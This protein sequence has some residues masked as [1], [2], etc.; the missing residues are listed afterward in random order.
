MESTRTLSLPI[1]IG[2]RLHAQRVLS[3]RSQHDIAT[4]IGV[5]QEYLSRLERGKWTAIR[6]KLLWDLA[7]AFG[8]SV[9]TLLV[10]DEED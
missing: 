2:R 5:S 1:R 8:V 3:G 7:A 10:G 6:P 9:T 4:N